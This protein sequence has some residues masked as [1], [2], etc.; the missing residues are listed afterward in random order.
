[1]ARKPRTRYTLRKIRFNDV[2]L[3]GQVVVRLGECTWTGAIKTAEG[4]KFR[5]SDLT[6]YSFR[7]E[8]K[9]FLR[10]HKLPCKTIELPKS[11]WE[12]WVT[13]VTATL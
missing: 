12:Q 2:S 8:D 13:E 6:H 7:L 5:K 10:Q 1:M 4:K 11:S 9:K 3:E